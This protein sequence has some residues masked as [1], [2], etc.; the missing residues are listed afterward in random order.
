MDIIKGGM[1]RLG[2]AVATSLLGRNIAKLGGHI[3]KLLKQ[4]LP[5]EAAK[6]SG[7]GLQV[8]QKEPES[9]GTISEDHSVHATTTIPSNARTIT[10]KIIPTSD[11]NK[12]NVLL[13]DIKPIP[14]QTLGK[15]QVAMKGKPHIPV[16]LKNLE[17]YKLNENEL[18]VLFSKVKAENINEYISALRTNGNIKEIDPE[19]KFHKTCLRTITTSSSLDTSKIH[20][21]IR[22]YFALMSLPKTDQ[23]INSMQGN[24]TEGIIRAAIIGVPI[25]SGI[26]AKWDSN[27]EK[28]KTGEKNNLILHDLISHNYSDDALFKFMQDKNIRYCGMHLST[29][30][31]G[32]AKFGKEG[33]LYDLIDLMIEKKGPKFVERLKDLPPAPQTTIDNP[34]ALKMLQKAMEDGKEITDVF[35]ADLEGR[36]L[37]E[38][39]LFDLFR[40]VKPENI[41]KY[42]RALRNNGN[43]GEIG[44]EFHNICLIKMAMEKRPE[45]LLEEVHKNIKEYFISMDLP[46]TD[47]YIDTMEGEMTKPIIKAAFGISEKTIKAAVIGVPIS[48]ET[49]E[50]WDSNNTYDNNLLLHNLI[51]HNHSDDELFKFMKEKNIKYCGMHLSTLFDGSAKFGKEG[52]LYDLIDLMIEKKGTKFVERLKDLP[53]APQTTID[54]PEALKMLQKDMENG[55]EITG[56]FNADLKGHTLNENELFDL[57]RKVKPENINKYISAL[58]SNGNIEK[59]DPKSEFHNICLIQM[60]MGKKPRG[61]LSLEEVHKNIKEYFISMDLPKTDEYI[62][63]MEGEM[64]KP[65]IKAALASEKEKVS[66]QQKTAAAAPAATP[67][68]PNPTVDAAKEKTDE[69]RLL[70][71]LG[72]VKAVMT[73]E[74]NIAGHIFLE[75]VKGKPMTIANFFNEDFFD[76]KKPQHIKT[77]HINGHLQALADND[78]IVIGE[79]GDAFH[80][81]F[82]KNFSEKKGDPISRD[83]KDY[84]TLM[85]LDQEKIIK[86]GKIGNMELAPGVIT[87]IKASFNRHAEPM[88]NKMDYTEYKKISNEV[89]CIESGMQDLKNRLLSQLDKT[90]QN[91]MY[92]EEQSI[93]IGKTKDDVFYIETGGQDRV[94][95]GLGKDGILING[96]P[97]KHL[98][99]EIEAE[100]E[101]I[102]KALKA[103]DDA[104]ALNVIGEHLHI[105]EINVLQEIEIPREKATSYQNRLLKQ[106]KDPNLLVATV[107]LDKEKGLW[108][109]MRRH[110]EHA[111]PGGGGAIVIVDKNVAPDLQNIAVIDLSTE[112]H[113]KVSEVGKKEYTTKK[114]AGE[115]VIEI[116]KPYEKRHNII[117]LAQEYLV[118]DSTVPIGKVYKTKWK[119]GTLDE[120]IGI[121]LELAGNAQYST[122][123]FLEFM[124]AVGVTHNGDL[125]NRPAKG[126]KGLSPKELIMQAR[127]DITDADMK[128]LPT[129]LTPYDPKK[130]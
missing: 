42:I 90:R 107:P 50:E 22:E 40:K 73:R 116:D 43:I 105:S 110:A 69:G 92:N 23:Y 38:N 53:P 111:L 12:P 31:N 25:S 45:R 41:N 129:S 71:Q 103:L 17:G 76:T 34:E 4:P 125:L 63:T 89:R 78:N 65:I 16:L 19:S 39:E 48:R 99:V 27:L 128:R 54:N 7:E 66:P 88:V 93:G 80:E 114:T 3:I 67:K 14:K 20:R 74:S 77:E 61:K 5:Q 119:E 96:R 102:D 109:E 91:Y 79:V 108:L 9:G 120:N 15:L 113:V 2:T 8:L 118:S 95:I 29:L 98:S 47:E 97:L 10:P 124:E 130:S 81:K 68:H 85:Q 122:D 70:H 58:R 46:K 56:V 11:P 104:K 13:V 86:D 94:S 87:S 127:K 59:I 100:K 82:L 18:L 123:D 126:G 32:T 44:R 26:M 121:L 51:T 64:T 6:T 52:E 30:F 62:D 117:N 1:E 75:E 37:N 57:F 33:E 106:L 36:K 21:K 35:N 49:K 83:I 55:K 60:A 28:D 24:K 84:F 101:I 72:R 112:G 115:G